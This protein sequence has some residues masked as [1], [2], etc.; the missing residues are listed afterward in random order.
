MLEDVPKSMPI[1]YKR[2]A[3][4]A[5]DWNMRYVNFQNLFSMLP[6]LTDAQIVSADGVLRGLESL[7]S[8]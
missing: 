3:W 6:F 5:I 8:R 7:P 4:P 1:I 2:G